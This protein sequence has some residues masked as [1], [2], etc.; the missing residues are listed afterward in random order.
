MKPFRD[1]KS[2]WRLE[3]ME[4]QKDFDQYLESK[5]APCQCKLISAG[6]VPA[7]GPVTEVSHKKHMMGKSKELSQACATSQQSF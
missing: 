1:G 4:V 3:E 6:S 5:P 2:S 7:D